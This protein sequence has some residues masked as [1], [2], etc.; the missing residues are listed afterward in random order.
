MIFLKNK[1]YN[2]EKAIEYA[3]KWAYKRNPQYYNFDDI[4]GDC[5]SFISQCIYAGSNIMNYKKYIGWYY[6]SV[7]DRTASWSGVEFLYNFLI[8]N[9]GVGPRATDT[10]NIEELDIGDIIQLKLTN[11]IF[12]HSLIIVEKIGSTLDKIYISTHTDD[13]YFRKVSTYNFKDIRFLHITDV[14]IW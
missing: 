8:N 3:R 9:K 14:G 5:T 12:S 10:R 11:S 1:S 2:R 6:N 4:G 13:S 7:N